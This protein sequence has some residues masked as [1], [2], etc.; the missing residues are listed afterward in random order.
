ME[1]TR[2]YKDERPVKTVEASGKGDVV[3]PVLFGRGDR[4]T[5]T[6][7]ATASRGAVSIQY[8]VG[9]DALERQ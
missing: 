8:K 7:I 6:A 4:G 5:A 1:T 3:F 9:R 2:R